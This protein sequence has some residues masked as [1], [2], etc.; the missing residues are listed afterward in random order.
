MRDPG[1]HLPR[2]TD[3]RLVRTCRRRSGSPVTQFAATGLLAVVVVG[4]VGVLF[5]RHVSRGEALRDAEALTRQAGEGIVAPAVTP[6]VLTGDPRTLAALDRVVRRSVL[7]DPVVRVK[8]WDATGRILYSDQPRLIG[9]RFVLGAQEVRVLRHGGVTAELSDLT[10][11]EN[12]FERGHGPLREVYVG[13]RGSGGRHLLFESYLREGA[14][15]SDS[16]RVWQDVVPVVLSMLVLLWLAQVP[17]ARSLATRLRR[18]QREREELLRHAVS[19]S[20]D[21]RRRLAADL[22]DGAVQDLVAISYTLGGVQGQIA[23]PEVAEVLDGS[24]RQ[25]RTV[26]RRLRTLLVELYPDDLHRQGLQAALSDL[27]AGMQGRGLATSLTVD[28][29]VDPD[30]GRSA[31]L[32]RAAQEA[33]RNVAP[34]AHA[35]RVDVHLGLAGDDWRLDVVDDGVGFGPADEDRSH[36]GLRLLADRAREAGGE[37]EI[38]STP[39]R[40][41]RVRLTV[42]ASG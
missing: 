26:I 10:R 27:L 15:S 19:A 5:V 18:G 3:T 13:I 24:G 12:R 31:L 34:H 33:L 40:G 41:T 16:R 11:R 17:L 42:P 28:A 39:G 2:A 21:E 29:P 32:F 9:E 35:G 37:L 22:H 4:I 30:R 7:R 14:L 36:F 6:G 23:D 8:L 25:V 38:Q 20:E 1:R